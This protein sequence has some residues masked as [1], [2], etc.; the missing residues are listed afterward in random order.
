MRSK[1]EFINDV[2]QNKNNRLILERLPILN[3]PD[4][5]LAAGCLFQTIWNLQSQRPAEENIKD[6]D[7]FYFSSDTSYE[8]ENEFIL[9]AKDAFKDLDINIEIRNQARVSIWYKEKFGGDYPELNQAKEGI[10]HFLIEC[11]CVGLQVSENGGIELYAPYGL[12]D[13]YDGKL[14]PNKNSFSKP[15]FTPLKVRSYQERWPWL[16]FVDTY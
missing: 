15:E 16:E 8:A 13:L 2:K 9:Y 12:E 4:V 1:Q 5:W 6:Y 7:L 3:I 11:T 10:N 14:K